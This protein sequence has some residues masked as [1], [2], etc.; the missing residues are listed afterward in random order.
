MIK[1]KRKELC[2]LLI[3][4]MLQ[5][6]LSCSFRFALLYMVFLHFLFIYMEKIIQLTINYYNFVT[7][8]IKHLKYRA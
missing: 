5:R 6:L 8:H 4:V 3:C 7:K 1:M 2:Y